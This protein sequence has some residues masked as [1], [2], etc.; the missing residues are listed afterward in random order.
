M[1][2]R[3]KEIM[4]LKLRVRRLEAK[5][6]RVLGGSAVPCPG[7]DGSPTGEEKKAADGDEKQGNEEEC[8]PTEAA[9]T[10]TNRTL[11]GE[12]LVILRNNHERVPSIVRQLRANQLSG[13]MAT[14]IPSDLREA[15]E[16]IYELKVQFLNLQGVML[17]WAIRNKKIRDYTLKKKRGD[18]SD[19]SASTVRRPR[20]R[21]LLRLEAA[22]KAMFTEA[23]IRAI[24]RDHSDASCGESTKKLRKNH[25]GEEDL[26][27][28]LELRA[29]SSDKVLEH[30]REKMK[31]PLPTL[32][33]TRLRCKMSPMLT[34]A[35]KEMLQKREQNKKLCDKCE[36]Q[37]NTIDSV[38][39]A[40]DSKSAEVEVESPF[41]CQFEQR[42]PKYDHDTAG[43]R[44]KKR[45]RTAAAATSAAK[46]N[47]RAAAAL[48][49]PDT[50][51]SDAE[52]CRTS[53]RTSWQ[54]L[55]ANVELGRLAA[56]Q[57][58]VRPLGDGELKR[59]WR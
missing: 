9:P 5:C 30:V 21:K 36:R 43:A 56:A 7:A 3:T 28:M 48:D 47:C 16:L 13:R 46:K 15:K 27:R 23:Q 40:M 10:A 18:G 42:V 22:V 50:S 26:R 2:E 17:K 12:P 25:W 4:R 6:L 54:P 57:L 55:A 51:D 34:E 39:D 24:I 33:I 11:G 41:G 58:D 29:I 8:P 53:S 45:R 52:L 1:L 32:H 31:I 19:E 14:F 35:Y 38:A 59:H 44:P 49:W 20:L 37:I